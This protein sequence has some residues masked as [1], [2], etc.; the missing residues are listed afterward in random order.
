MTGIDTNILLAALVSG[1][2]HHEPARK[3][4]KEISDRSDVVISEFVLVEVFT[5]L[6]NRVVMS[7]P[8]DSAGAAAVCQ[9]FRTHPYWR[10][11]GFPPESEKLH[12]DLWEKAAGKG[13]S[14]RRIYDLRL[15]LCLSRFGVR[16]FATVNIKDFNGLGFER[17][18][19]PLGGS[20]P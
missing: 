6:M 17:V 12:S 13:M 19:N 11:L 20:Q 10:C 1:H 16:D 9:N 4:I 3:W 8:L 14:R 2:S 15:G 5:L 18:W 7:K